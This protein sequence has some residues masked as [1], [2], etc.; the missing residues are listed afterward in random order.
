MNVSGACSISYLS[1]Y[2]SREFKSSPSSVL[3][4]LYCLYGVAVEL[5]SSMLDTLGSRFGS[6][7]SPGFC[8]SSAKLRSGFTVL[9]LK[10]KQYSPP[11]S[12]AAPPP[13]PAR[14]SVSGP[15]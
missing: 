12:G 8:P 15:N 14:H 4:V 3:M 13:P 10:R 2:S 7:P 9:Y 11:P 5:K 6:R 1:S